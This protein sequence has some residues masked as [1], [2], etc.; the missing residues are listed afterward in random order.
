MSA[1]ELTE[2]NFMVNSKKNIFFSY[3][4]LQTQLSIFGHRDVPK[5]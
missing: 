5:P 4:H 3:I 1:N 2:N